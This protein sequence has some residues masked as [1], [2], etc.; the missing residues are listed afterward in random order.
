[1]IWVKDPLI[2]RASFPSAL[3]SSRNNGGNRRW[4]MG[5]GN[6]CGRFA[7]D[8][9]PGLSGDRH[10]WGEQSPAR[11]NFGCNELSMVA[12]CKRLTKDKLT[13]NREKALCREV[14]G[15]NDEFSLHGASPQ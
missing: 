1:L 12:W 13:I 9:R 5:L 7:D 10:H 2:S 8:Y 4:Y 11:G 15:P 14:P 3:F 6:S